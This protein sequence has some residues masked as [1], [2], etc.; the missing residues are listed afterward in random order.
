MIKIVSLKGLTFPRL[1]ITGLILTGIMMIMSASQIKAQ[2]LWSLEDCINYAF[3]HNLDIKKQVLVVETN[4]ANLNQA[5]LNTLPSINAGASTVNNWGRTIDQ[6]TNE[7]ATNRVR[8]DN[9]Y[10]Q[11]NLTLF[12]GLQKINMIKRNQLSL[13]F[14]QYSLDDLMDNI[15]LTVAGYYLDILF[16][17][18]LLVVANERLHVT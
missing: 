1:L 7:F 9:L 12:S 15:S 3:D 4:K 10:V 11:G 16:N 8:S 18:E 2:A 14:S 6:Y 17:R 13:K 5:K